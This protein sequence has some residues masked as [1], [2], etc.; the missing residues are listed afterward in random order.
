MIDYI[1]QQK[2]V[3]DRHRSAALLKERERYLSHLHEQ[4]LPRENLSTTANLLLQVIRI[5]SLSELRLVREE[6]VRDAATRWAKDVDGHISR[7][8]GPFSEKRFRWCAIHWF[9][10]NGVLVPT[11]SPEPP[12]FE[13]LADFVRTRREKGLSP[14]TVRSYFE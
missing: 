13:L 9:S 10:I 4:G 3:Q 5:M 2:R 11:P 1:Y 6:E 14:A 12:F 7:G 8:P